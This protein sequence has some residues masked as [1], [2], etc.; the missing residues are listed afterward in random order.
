[1]LLT[2]KSYR[3]A[4]TGYRIGADCSPDLGRPVEQAYRQVVRSCLGAMMAR[5]VGGGRSRN[6]IVFL[7]LLRTNSGHDRGMNCS[8]PVV[9]GVGRSVAVEWVCETSFV[10]HWDSAHA[11]ALADGKGWYFDPDTRLLVLTE[12]SHLARGHCCSSGCRH[13][14]YPLEATEADGPE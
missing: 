10:N 12:I 14:P 3:F 4:T 8:I 9:V 5:S 7:S 6:L 2:T 1:M 13:C 11:D